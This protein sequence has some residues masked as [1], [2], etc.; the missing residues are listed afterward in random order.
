[1]SNAIKN[2]YLLFIW[3]VI[4]DKN[5]TT[6]QMSVKSSRTISYSIRNS[7]VY[8]TDSIDCIKALSV[9]GGGLFLFVSGRR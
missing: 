2:V 6:T 9:A 1:M 8:S 7:L 5:K 4:I 3:N